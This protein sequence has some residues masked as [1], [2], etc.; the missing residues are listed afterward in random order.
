MM[1]EEEILMLK[2]P[3]LFEWKD[4]IILLGEILRPFS[5]PHISINL[6][7]KLTPFRSW[8]T[9]IDGYD[10]CIQ[11]TEI[12][13]NGNILRNIQI[14]SINLFSLP[15]HVSFKISQILLGNDPTTV[16]FSFVKDNKKVISWSR[17]ENLSGNEIELKKQQT[18]LHEYMGKQFSV[19]TSF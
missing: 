5:Y 10:V 8:R 12:I 15:F 14:Y 7:Y 17:M 3:N 9:D 2:C 4:K 1:K 13:L 19:I 6:E 18:E 11:Y 16:Y